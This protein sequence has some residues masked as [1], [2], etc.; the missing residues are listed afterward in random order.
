MCFLSLHYTHGWL[1]LFQ[2]PV[3][4]VVNAMLAA[5]A[6]H[7]ARMEE[8]KIYHITSSVTNPILCQDL[9]GY[10]FEHFEPFPYIDNNG[11]PVRVQPMKFFSSEDELL[12]DIWTNAIHRRGEASVAGLAEKPSQ[13][14]ER[15][16]KIQ[17]EQVKRLSNR[18]QAY[19]FYAGRYD[20]LVTQ[21]SLVPTMLGST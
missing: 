10:F 8:M 14:V 7:S 15:I 21:R 5:M 4:M 6:K 3:D 1:H 17:A 2:I 9:Y 12:S 16:W 13:R 11:K 20:I 18:Y 19:C